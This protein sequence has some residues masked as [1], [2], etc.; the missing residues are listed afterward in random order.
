MKRLLCFLAVILCLCACVS[1]V[2]VGEIVPGGKAPIPAHATLHGDIAFTAQERAVIQ[3]AADLW[4]KQTGKVAVVTLFWDVNFDSPL[5]LR[6]HVDAGDNI[7]VRVDSDM[8]TVQE[9]DEQANPGHVLG[10]VTPAGGIHNPWWRPILVAFVAD[11]LGDPDYMRLVVLHEF[12]HVLGMPHSNDVHAIMYP[13]AIPDT[14]VCLKHSDLVQFCA[15][16]ECKDARMVP[17]E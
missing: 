17:C 13:A 16:N 6:E 7:M 15:I 9:M 8:A 1:Q 3:S 10:W 11:R 2:G 14:S 12:G 4:Y 5:N